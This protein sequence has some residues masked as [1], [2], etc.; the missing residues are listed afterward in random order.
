MDIIIKDTT[1]IS[2]EL[3]LD[4]LSYDLNLNLENV[5][6]DLISSANF[7]DIVDRENEEI[8]YAM[9]FM[10]KSVKVLEGH[11][12]VPFKVVDYFMSNTKGEKLGH[13]APFHFKGSCDDMLYVFTLAY[14]SL[15]LIIEVE[16]KFNAEDQ[17]IYLRPLE[18]CVEYFS[19]YTFKAQVKHITHLPDDFSS[20]MDNRH[21]VSI[22]FNNK[23]G[24]LSNLISLLD[25][26]AQN[27]I[28]IFK[29]KDPDWLFAYLNNC[30]YLNVII[31]KRHDFISEVINGVFA[32]MFAIKEDDIAIRLSR[33]SKHHITQSNISLPFIVTV[34][35]SIDFSCCLL[36]TSPNNNE[37][38][39]YLYRR[40]LITYW[41][42]ISKTL[43]VSICIEGCGNY[44]PVAYL[45]GDWV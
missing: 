14:G 1:Y 3:S 16:Y 39:R 22:N 29:L 21:N 4:D 12:Q 5:F 38:T 34:D 17:D 6:R 9:L 35:N 10:Q 42:Q 36:L 37:Q 40:P 15:A 33:L 31:S 13:Y 45:F 28:K 23:T 8:F 30:R 18:E 27:Q 24:L 26:T 7:Q 20:H 11:F 43:E 2:I 19:D 41:E 44:D 32:K 25:K